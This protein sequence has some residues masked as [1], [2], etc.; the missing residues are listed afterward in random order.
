MDPRDSCLTPHYVVRLRRS[1]FSKI[2][3]EELCRTHH[4]VVRLRRLPSASLP[5]ASSEVKNILLFL[6]KGST[7]EKESPSGL[8]PER[9]LV[10]SDKH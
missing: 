3:D 1:P 7:P 6:H 4:L 2:L 10:R 9:A 5:K 8:M